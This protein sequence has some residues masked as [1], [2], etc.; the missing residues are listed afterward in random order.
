MI[1][2]NSL[3]T[4][5][6]AHSFA[7][8]VHIGGGLQEDELGVLNASRSDISIALGLEACTHAL[9]ECVSDAEADIMAC[10]FVLP[11]DVAETYDEVFHISVEYLVVRGW[12]SLPLHHY[13][14]E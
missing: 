12:V 5:P 7:T 8:E 1:N 11:T 10:R 3:G 2:S 4:H 14:N 13:I 9:G 6:V